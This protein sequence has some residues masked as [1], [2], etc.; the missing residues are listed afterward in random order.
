MSESPA[1]RQA[2]R[3]LLRYRPG[4]GGHAPH[5]EGDG[6]LE[7]QVNRLGRY[8]QSSR[9]FARDR[10]QGLR[11]LSLPSL[12]PAHLPSA[13][14]PGGRLPS[15]GMPTVSPSIPSGGGSGSRL[16]L[17]ALVVLLGFAVWRLVL[18]SPLLA[19]DGGGWRLGPW[20]VSPGAVASREDLIRAFEY[21]SLLKLGPAARSWNH[22]EICAGLSGTEPQRRRA[23]EHLAGLYEQARYAPGSEPLSE[24]AL[25]SARREL[26]F[27]AGVASA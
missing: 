14:W 18:R 7:D 19:G 22:R 20:P 8:V 10:W 4:A 6:A 17:V 27:L 16:L 24:E 2:I 23:A 1:L 13:G 26:S 25:A 5:L 12:T 9:L 15:L 11:M 21:L 3:D